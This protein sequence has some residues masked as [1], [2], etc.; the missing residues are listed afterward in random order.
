MVGGTIMALPTRSEWP[1]VEEKPDEELMKRK[2][3]NDFDSSKPWRQYG[4][5]TMEIQPFDCRLAGRLVGEACANGETNLR[6]VLGRTSLNYEELYTILCDCEQVINSRPI[7]YVSEH[8]Q[9]LSPLTSMMFLQE[10]PSSG[11]PDI[12]CVDSKYRQRIR[13]DLRNS[14]RSEYLGQLRQ[15]T[16]KNGKLQQLQV[17][18]V[19]LLEDSQTRRIHWLLAK[20]IEPLRSTDGIVRLVRV[21]TRNG[22]LLRP[23]PQ[24]FPLEISTSESAGPPYTDRARRDRNNSATG[25]ADQAASVPESTSSPRVVTRGGRVVQPPHRLDLCTL[26]S[27][28]PSDFSGGSRCYIS[29]PN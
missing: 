14:F 26:S 12:D 23:V 4:L 9:D 20:L 18:D 5:D 22:T 1:H 2:K 25:Q 28:A 24:L 16:R 8:N 10:L 11:V 21:K 3:E 17:G 15:Q 27:S 29:T 19:I 7:T 13:L 6:R